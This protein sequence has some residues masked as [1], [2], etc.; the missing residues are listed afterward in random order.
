MAA[1]SDG[2]DNDGDGLV[3]CEDA[4]CREVYSEVCATEENTEALCNDGIDNNGDGLV[5]C[6]DAACSSIWPC[7]VSNAKSSSK[8]D[9]RVY[10]QGAY[11]G[12]SRTM[13]TDL[14][15]LGY[16]P[17]QQPTTLMGQSKVNQLPYDGGPWFFFDKN[18]DKRIRSKSSSVYTEQSVDWVVISLKNSV[19][20]QDVIWTGM[21]IV[22]KDGFI[23]IQSALDI[24][25]GDYYVMIEHRNHMP[26]ISATKVVYTNGGWSYDFTSNDSY[27]SGVTQGQILSQEGD[28]M[29]IG[30]NGDYILNASSYNDI[31]ILDL[32][33]WRFNNGQNS[34][35][36]IED[37]DM[38]GC[39]LYTSPSP[40]DQRGSRMPS[41]A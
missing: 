11:D 34:G 19:D 6:E 27:R 23:D 21:G 14:N 12:S 8:L 36:F 15:R 17:G 3:D 26:V 28:Y 10:L 38:N 18:I 32:N 25:Q 31:N 22:E 39:L 35:Y 24:K 9:L 4:N 33:E 16:L 41:S 29:M 5:D 37:Y 30:A 13:R 20:V 7:N 1:C 40:R 2:I